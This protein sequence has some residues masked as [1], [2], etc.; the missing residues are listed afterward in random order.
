MALKVY[1]EE[2]PKP[3]PEQLK[4]PGAVTYTLKGKA[5]YKEDKGANETA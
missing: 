3:K 2:K 5:T 1:P 4:E